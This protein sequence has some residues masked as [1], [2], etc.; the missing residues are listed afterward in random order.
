VKDR[1]R[2]RAKA[3][4]AVLA[5]DIPDFSVRIARFAAELAPAPGSVIAGYH[6]LQDEADP[7]ALMKALAAMGCRLALPVIR[8]GSQLDF[9]E[10]RFGAPTRLNRYGIA[11]PEHPRVRLEPSLILVP[12]LAFDSAG[13]RLGYGGGYYDRTLEHSEAIAAGIAYA[14]QEVEKLPR[15]SHDR[16]LDLVVTENGVRKFG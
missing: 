4:R 7:L 9:A 15:E 3:H 12:L 2:E 5:R 13:H 6:P 14:G 8:F 11:E 1:L 16:A 10:W